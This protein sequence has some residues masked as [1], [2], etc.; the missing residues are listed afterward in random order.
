M[1]HEGSRAA[2]RI[3]AATRVLVTGGAGFIGSHLVDV[4]RAR[5]ARVVVLDDLTTGQRSNLAHSESGDVELVEGST[6]DAALVEQLMADAD[7]CFHLASA[8]GVQLVV[9]NPLESLLKNVRGTDIVM[10]AAARH[11]TR[12][13]FTST[14]EVYGKNSSGSL[15]EEAD[16]LLGSPFK[17]RWCYETSKAFGECLAH[18]YHRDQGA[19]MT[20][21]RLFN[22]V[23]PRQVSQY[24]MVVPT[25][26]RQ[27][28]AGE[29]LTVYGDGSQTRCFS[30]V[31]D[32]VRGLVELMDVDGSVGRVF[33]I[34][35]ST[36]VPI[37]ELA[38][39]VIE[40]VGSS[41]EIDFVPYAD[42]Y[43][44]GFEELGRRKPDTSA[45][46]Q[47]IGWAPQ[48]SVDDAIRDV[49]AFERRR[50]EGAPVA[51]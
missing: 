33:N 9:S 10:A 18:S 40:H 20:V 41:S 35:S 23:G 1:A 3:G 19:R 17:A 45:I 47:L 42:A 36:E 15:D 37:V 32:A 24:G 2:A 13:L 31:T 34:G 25:F 46:R 12:L 48:L 11:E 16:R 14:S 27:A 8:V 51:A 4:L 38:R 39:R 5:D 26:V 44:V 29:P 22:T 30:H 28:L 49:V 7:L 21:V 50:R 43:D 6:N